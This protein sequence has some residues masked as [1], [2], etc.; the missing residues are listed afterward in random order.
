[1]MAQPAVA[2]VEKKR[3]S[4]ESQ[5]LVDAE[6]FHSFLVSRFSFPEHKPSFYY[7][8]RCNKGAAVS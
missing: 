8:P 7:F 1:M 5:H 2:A 3:R 4:E 6:I